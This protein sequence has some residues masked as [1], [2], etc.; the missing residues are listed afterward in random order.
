MAPAPPVKRP[1]SESDPSVTHTYDY[2]GTYMV[3]LLVDYAGTYSFAGPGGTGTESLGNYVDRP[4]QAR[5]T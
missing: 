1:G 2:K 5:L 4:G 3:S